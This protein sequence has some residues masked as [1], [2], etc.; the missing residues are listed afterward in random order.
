MLTLVLVAIALAL[1][2]A[3]MMSLLTYLILRLR[4]IARRDVV[5]QAA[6]DEVTAEIQATSAAIT[7]TWRDM[8][9]LRVGERRALQ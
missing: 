9:A 7:Q 4:V 2:F 1:S 6:L 5:R 3:V 8:E